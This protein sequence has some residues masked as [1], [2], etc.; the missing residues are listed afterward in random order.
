M[1]A[2]PSRQAK[3]PETPRPMTRKATRHSVQGML[4]AVRGS[5]GDRATAQL[6]DFSAFGCNIVSDA[7]WLRMGCFISLRLSDDVT[8]QAIVR[9]VRNGACGVE[10]LRPLPY[11]DAEAFAR[12]C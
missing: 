3:L 2:K 8:V 9:W 7:P 11:A 12:G 6:N 4:V 10:F 1:S 5:Q